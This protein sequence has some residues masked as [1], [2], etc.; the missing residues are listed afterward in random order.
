MYRARHFE[1]NSASQV[2]FLHH[3]LT[4]MPAGGASQDAC[5]SL[6]A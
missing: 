2:F 6:A 4:V 3:Q 1:P 5:L